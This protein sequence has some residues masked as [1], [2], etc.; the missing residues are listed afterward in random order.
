M[1][2]PKDLYIYAT[3]QPI[4]TVGTS[5]IQYEIHRYHDFR[6]QTNTLAYIVVCTHRIIVPAATPYQ[7]GPNPGAFTGY[8]NYP[9]AIANNITAAAGPSASDATVLLKE[10]F[11]R[12]LNASI[13]TSI[14][15]QASTNNSLTTQQSSGSSTSQ[16]NTFGV[17]ISGGF[18]GE[19]P[20]GNLSLDYQHSW[21]SGTFASTGSGTDAGHQA[22][23]TSGETMSIKDWS[24]YGYADAKSKS[25][26]WV[27]G[28]SYP[29]D[30]ILYNQSQSS[31][32]VTLPPFVRSRL[33][34]T[35]IGG[36]PTAPT[37]TTFALPPSQLSL[38]GLDFTMK[39]SWLIEFPK[40]VAAPE[41][42][43]LTH[44]L[45]YYTAS[46]SVTGS[47][48]TASLTATINSVSSQT[49]WTSPALDLSSYALDPILTVKSGAAVNL[50]AANLFTYPPTAAG[51]PFK[52]VSAPN[53]LQVTG[54]GFGPQMTSDFKNGAT[55]VA[56]V[57]KILDTDGEYSLLLHHW[58]GAA[59]SAVT[60]SVV[61][62]GS[63]PT[64]IYV[65]AL[66]GQ[67][68]QNN[69]ST[70]ALRDL[71]FSS[72]NFH[73]YLRLGLNTIEIEI[74]PVNPGLSN[75]YTLS[76]LAIGQG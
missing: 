18:F 35:I 58:I 31:G 53:N 9:A 62:N 59:G 15:E 10:L 32:T 24:S 61:V 49:T 54:E 68:G 6:S 2:N 30:V 71:N 64:V 20:V 73:D 45:S 34:T 27:W 26:N 8:S 63:A 28:Q 50:M 67:G 47:G 12:T 21:G 48:P 57:F 65:D 75:L 14:E 17:A 7:V 52:M 37:Y 33:M 70:I 42:V 41:T 16:S 43:S 69:V 38:F 1:I 66:E 76:A 60:L 25:P 72:V 23:S 5:L 55:S 46:H 36:T 51:G 40:G 22:G 11:P 74:S 19:L 39:A 13:S 44:N 3:T 4:G 29:W 56:A